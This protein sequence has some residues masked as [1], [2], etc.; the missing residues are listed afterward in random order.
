MVEMPPSPHHLHPTT[1]VWW[2]C[3]GGGNVRKQVIATVLITVFLVGCA[4]ART[5][6]LNGDFAPISVEEVTIVG[7]RDDLP[8]DDLDC[9]TV[10]YIESQE[11][12]LNSTRKMLE[13]VKGEAAKN[14]ANYV[15]FKGFDNGGFVW[16][17]GDEANAVAYRCV[18]SHFT[19][20][21]KPHLPLKA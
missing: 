14:G 10:A 6:V 3:P 18:P 20:P 13:K 21:P 19:D 8:D 1:F 17:E 4:M 5:N 9:V 12:W 15:V 11:M 16:D 2:R 7:H